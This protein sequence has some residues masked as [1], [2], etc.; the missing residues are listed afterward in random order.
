VKSQ[1]FPG[2]IATDIVFEVAHG[3]KKKENTHFYVTSGVGLVGP[4]YRI[5]SVSEI[6]MITVTFKDKR[7]HQ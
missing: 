5:G 6:A 1:A 4:Q 3:Y 7:N 2:N